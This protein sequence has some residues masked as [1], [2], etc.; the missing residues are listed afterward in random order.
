MQSNEQLED[1]LVIQPLINRDSIT[2]SHKLIIFA[3]LSFLGTAVLAF[4]VLSFS[5][6]RV[7]D[8]INQALIGSNNIDR[9]SLLLRLFVPTLLFLVALISSFIGYGLLRRAGAGSKP[10]IPI[11]DSQLISA[12][13]MKSTDGI[14]DYI[15]LSGLT[16]VMGYFIKIGVSGLPLATILLTVF[17]TILAIQNGNNKELLDLVR[18]TLGAF[19]GSFVQRHIG[20]NP[21]LGTYP[22][23]PINAL[24]EAAKTQVEAA[25]KQKIAAEEQKVAADTQKEAA[26]E[27]KAD[28]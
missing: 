11:Q 2:Q 24:K 7:G 27:Q 4:I 12:L 8:S 9:A 3:S 22:Q 14:S 18:L 13:L 19:I 5:L 6:Y 28:E 20:E 10:V 15:R 23:P 26:E 16:G 21:M 17:F 25:D 1:N